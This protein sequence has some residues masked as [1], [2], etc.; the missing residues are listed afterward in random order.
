MR[1]IYAVNKSTE[2]FLLIL[3]G[4]LLAITAQAQENVL[5]TNVL[6]LLNNQTGLEYE[7]RLSGT[8]SILFDLNHTFDYKETAKIDFVRA[9]HL[10]IDYRFFPSNVLDDAPHK[11]YVGPTVY[12]AFVNK[13][14]SGSVFIN[15]KIVAMNIVDS[16]V[17]VGFGIIGGYQYIFRNKLAFDIHVNPTFRK[18][19]IKDSNENKANLDESQIVVERFGLSFGFAF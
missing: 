2:Y 16:F 10:G 19:L 13:E 18:S 5:K 9:W 1:H 6:N 8:S 4:I 14:F 7:R 17:N 11:F 12:A 15:E 3:I